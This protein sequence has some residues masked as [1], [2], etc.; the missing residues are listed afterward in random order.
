MVQTEVLAVS[1]TEWPIEKAIERI[2]KDLNKGGVSL[3]GKII[4][5]SAPPREI[6]RIADGESP[7]E[8][9][10]RWLNTVDDRVISGAAQW[11]HSLYACRL[12]AAAPEERTTYYIDR[13][14]LPTNLHLTIRDAGGKRTSKQAP[15]S[16]DPQQD[17]KTEP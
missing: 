2:E 10:Y 12:L 8:K 16:Y 15:F 11:D 5:Y 17:Y 13:S 4:D 3:R 9:Q 7:S 6:A 14:V 1:V